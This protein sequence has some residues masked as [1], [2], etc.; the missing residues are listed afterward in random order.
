MNITTEQLAYAFLV[1]SGVLAIF[2]LFFFAV[3]LKT[4]HRVHD[5]V[6]SVIALIER[7]EAHYEDFKHEGTNTD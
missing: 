6:K 4:I 5:M 2:A 1:D 7:V 3:S